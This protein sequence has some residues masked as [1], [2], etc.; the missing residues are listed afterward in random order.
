MGINRTIAPPIREIESFNIVKATK[1]NLSNGIPFYHLSDHNGDLVKIEW[2]FSAGNWY[3]P[4]PLV[5]FTVNNMLVEGSQKYTSLQIAEL[6]EYYGAY[7]S[8]NIDRD[9]ALVTLVCMHKYLSE[10]LEIVE[11]IIKNAT[12][13]ENE[14]ETFKNKHK[15]QFLI[16][17]SMVKNI[18]RAVHA[19]MLFGNDH[20]YG[21]MIVENDFDRL[22]RDAL[23]KFY[24]ERYQSKHC[25]IVASGKVDDSVIKTIEKYFGGSTWNNSK[26]EFS[27]LFEIKTENERQIYIKKPGAVQSAV[28]IG[29]VLFNKLHQDYTGMSIVGCILGG[30]M[31]SRL[32]KKI[33]E[34][35]GYTY[36]INS[37]VVTFKNAGCLIIASELGAQVTLP[38]ID[39]IYTE[40][41]KLRNEPI[42]QE[43]LNRVKN[44][45]LGD[46]LRM[47]DGSFAQAESLISLLE[48]DLDYDYFTKIISTIKNITTNDIQA[49]AQKYLDP[50]SFSQVVV[51]DY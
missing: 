39:D 37:I 51:G 23:I 9:H 30:Y 29:K 12:F 49:L 2:M 42:A 7:L 14:I 1:H 4:S 50:A 40:I 26:Q 24:Q 3:Q 41:E 27:G 21:Y 45:M 36:G 43:E 28:R 34:E 47:F 17:Q 10:V 31:G 5:A 6:I 44:Y 25:K 22:N 18:A 8:Y 32:M 20:P 15:Q 13:P 35:K 16:E 48:Y 38:A 11:D 46:V 33:R 19:R